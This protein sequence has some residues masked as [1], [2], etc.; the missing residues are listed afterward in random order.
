MIVL[1]VYIRKDTHLREALTLALVNVV[2]IDESP[3]LL[4]VRISHIITCIT[5]PVQAAIGVQA[6]CVA[7]CDTVEP[8]LIATE[9]LAF[10]SKSSTNK[11]DSDLTIAIP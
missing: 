9:M 6:I 8:D 10:P 7:M 11:N 1:Q 3:A 4:S 2:S 5:T